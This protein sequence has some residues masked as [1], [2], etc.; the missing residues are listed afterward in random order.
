L[1]SYKVTAAAVQAVV[2]YPGGFTPG[3]TTADI[4]AYRSFVN[5]V[6]DAHF[7]LQRVDDRKPAWPR[8]RTGPASV[9]V[10]AALNGRVNLRL[11]PGDYDQ[12][13]R[14]AR[15]RGVELAALIRQ[16]L[17]AY[18]ATQATRRRRGRNQ[19]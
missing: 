9:G 11:A 15:R 17:S 10:D 7:R 16:T 5:K 6:V 19:S 4:R 12:L 18:L 13:D 8:R 3:L 1:R 2:G 14:I